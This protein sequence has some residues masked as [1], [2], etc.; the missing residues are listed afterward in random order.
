MLAVS[1]RSLL[2]QTLLALSFVSTA[3]LACPAGQT[4]VCM[5]TCFCAPGGE[6]DMAPLL[7]NVNRVAAGSLQ[8]W[9]VQSRNNLASGQIQPIPLHIRA[10]LEPYYDLRVLDTVRY[11]VGIDGE[12]N[13]ANTLMQNPDVEAVT[14]VDVIVFR[15]P[16]DA[17]DNVALWAHELKHVQQ[18]L[19]WGVQD[20][21]LRYTRDF[22]AV[23]APAYKIQVEVARALRPTV[24]SS[25]GQQPAAGTHRD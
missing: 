14:L 20:F 19:D 2:A 9:I 18:Y 21:A 8:Q 12:L 22:N 25:A 6:G 7:E 24:V 13:A 17:Q 23:E 15:N 4:Q 1:P 3:A 16:Q 11:K 5:V 10:Q